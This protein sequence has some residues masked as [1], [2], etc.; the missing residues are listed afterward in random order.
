MLKKAV[1]IDA[2][3]ELQE[4]FPEAQPVQCRVED[5]DRLREVRLFNAHVREA[6]D[7]RVHTLLADIAKE[8]LARELVLAPA[9]IAGLTASLLARHAS[10]SPFRMR[11]HSQDVLSLNA[12]GVPVFA[13]ESLQPGDAVV[14][15]RNGSIDVTLATRLEDVLA[16]G[17]RS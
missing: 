13:D 4:V 8:I 9:D 15:L 16:C 3:V 7:R 2:P 1:A 17:V 5:E 11:V 10:A 14:D 6:L 12:C